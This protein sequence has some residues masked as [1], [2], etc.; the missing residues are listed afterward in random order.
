MARF[1]L[2]FVVVVTFAT[3]LSGCSD[4]YSQ[5]R[6]ERRQQNRERFF[7]G[8]VD[9]ESRR[10]EKLKR[11]GEMFEGMHQRKFEQFERVQTEIGYYLW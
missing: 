9:S 10:P 8:V 7:K 5:K 6:I 1:L 4:P 2:L 3:N 11:T